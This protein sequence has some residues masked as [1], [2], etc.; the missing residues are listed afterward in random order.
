MLTITARRI[1]AVDSGI[2][3]FVNM[4]GCAT[5]KDAEFVV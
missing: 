1:E 5:M 4:R 3:T 2:V